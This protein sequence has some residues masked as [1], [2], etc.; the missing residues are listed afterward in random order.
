MSRFRL[1][2][3]HPLMERL[4]KLID[5]ANDLGISIDYSYGNCRVFITD[6]L[7]GIEYTLE[8]AEDNSPVTYFPPSIEYKI[9]LKE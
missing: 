2:D 5:C 4:S 8:D 3:N 9:M 6:E 1:K 7:T